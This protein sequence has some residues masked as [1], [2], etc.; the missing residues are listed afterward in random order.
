MTAGKFPQIPIATLRLPVVV[1]P[2][3]D[4][5]NVALS[6]QG[7]G[8]ADEI[9][10]D[11]GL[12]ADDHACQQDGALIGELDLDGDGLAGFEV[13]VGRHLDRA[14]AEEGIAAL[15]IRGAGV[16][17]GLTVHPQNRTTGLGKGEAMSAGSLGDDRR[18]DARTPAFRLDPRGRR[19]EREQTGVGLLGDGNDVA[20]ERPSFEELDSSN[21]VEQW[22]GD[23][24][25]R[26]VDVGAAGVAN[27]EIGEAIDQRIERWGVV[28]GPDVGRAASHH[29]G[30]HRAGAD[31]GDR[32]EC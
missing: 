31:H 18:R 21:T 5:G 29:P 15:N 9:A 2:D 14:K 19:S 10:F 3:D 32:A 22:S 23:R 24:R 11:D 4:D 7:R 16:D 25:H 12:A 27:V 20:L 1:G 6:G 17:D 13:D 8:L 28:V 30:M 26:A